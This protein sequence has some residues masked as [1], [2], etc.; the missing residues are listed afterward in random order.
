MTTDGSRLMVRRDT[1]PR[2]FD[3]WTKGRDAHRRLREALGSP[4]GGPPKD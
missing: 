3:D 1:P 4:V 2:V